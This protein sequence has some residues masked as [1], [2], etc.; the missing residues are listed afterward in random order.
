MTDMD[1]LENAVH[2]M[3]AENTRLKAVNAELLA[4]LEEMVRYD[5]LPV[6]DQQPALERARAAIAKATSYPQQKE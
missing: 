3:L 6:R 2:K 1:N 4:A 5:D